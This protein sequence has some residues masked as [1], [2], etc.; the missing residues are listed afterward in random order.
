MRDGGKVVVM[1]AEETRGGQ[2][3][4]RLRGLP[5]VK[6]RAAGAALHDMCQHRKVSG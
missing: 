5:L 6:T 1:G 4:R 2:Q 3:E